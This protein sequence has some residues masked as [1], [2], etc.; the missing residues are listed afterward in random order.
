MAFTN[1]KESGLEALI[2]KWLVDQNGYEQGT[3]ADYN[4]EYAVDETR[5]FRF[6]QDTQPDALEKLGVFK[7]DMKKKQFLNRLQGEIAKRGII[8]VLRNGVKIYPANLIMFYLT[9]TENNAKAKEMFEKNI[10]S[11]TRQLQYSMDAARL[12]LDICLFIN[13]LPVITFELKNQLTKQNTEYAVQQYKDDRD[14]TRPI[15]TQESCCSSSNA[16]WCILPLTTH[17]S[18]SAQSWTVRTAGS[19]LLIKATMMV[20]VI[21]RIQMA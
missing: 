18:N 11:V 7:S 17:E 5:L 6:L 2:V 3:N 1:T 14:P 19:C 20:P 10:F 9:P 12:A 16:A 21:L 4:R 15:V 13:G 8:D